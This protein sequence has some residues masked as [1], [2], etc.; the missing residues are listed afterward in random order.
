M[1]HRIAFACSVVART[2]RLPAPSVYFTP[3]VSQFDIGGDFGVQEGTTVNGRASIESLGVEE[4]SSV[5][6]GRVDLLAFGHWTFS[7]Q[8]STHDGEGT[9]DAELSSGGIT[10]NA[11]DPVK[12]EW[13]SACIPGSVTFDLVPSDT[14]EVGFGLGVAVLDTDASFTNQTTSEEVATDESFPFRTWPAASARTS[15]RSKSRRLVNW[16]DLSYDDTSASFL[17]V[18]TMARLRVFGDSDRF[19]GYVALG[20]RFLNVQADYE[21]DGDAIDFDVEFDGPWVGLSVSF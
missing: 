13:N 14:F 21:S 5:L 17:D 18:D 2:R 7:G 15:G 6:G 1:S 10:I 16:I 4:D 12:S 3:R 9:A 20:Y 19:S 8:Q 11:G